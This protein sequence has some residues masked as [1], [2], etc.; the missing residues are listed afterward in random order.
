VNFYEYQRWATAPTDLVTGYFLHRLKDGGSYAR[1]TAA[2]EGARSDFLLQ[3]RIHRFEEVDRGKEVLASV[4]LEVELVNARTRASVW[5]GEAE[6]TRPLATR[7]LTGVVRG[8]HECLDETTSKLL[9]SM[10]SRV[11]AVRD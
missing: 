10:R 6:C 8:I 1:V 3:G 7:D 2:G 9:A 4:A 5:R 11:E